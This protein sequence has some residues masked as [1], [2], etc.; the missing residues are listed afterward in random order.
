[1]SAA[2][3]LAR[4]GLGNVWPNPAVGCVIVADGADGGEV[5][6]RGWTQPG[7][8]PHAET[9]ALARAGELA[10]GA[11]AYVTLEPCSHHGKT[12]PCA[13]AL[14]EAGVRRVVAAIADPDPRVGGRGFEKLRKAGIEVETG[15]LAE[16]AEEVNLGYLMR[17]R[18]GRPMITLK[19]ATTLDG[20]IATHRGD[21]QWIT[22]EAARR[23]AHLLR[24]THDAVLVGIGTALA[25]D[26]RLTC[27]LPGLEIRSPVR[28]VADPRLQLPLMSQLARNADEAPTWLLTSAETPRERRTPDSRPPT[29]PERRA[30]FEELG[31]TVLPVRVGADHYPEIDA[32]LKCLG[33]AGLTRVLLE[34]GGG[35]AAA[36]IRA[37]VVDQILWFRAAGIMGGD[38]IA[39]VAPFGVDTLDDLRRFERVSV[40]SVGEDWLE[41]YRVVN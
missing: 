12:P 22:G 18:V 16:A 13:D 29:P 5:V 7:G 23:R 21:S 30:A 3:A 11:T 36:F 19:T 15:L 1:M 31:V 38:G 26:P 4:R 20:R 39:A 34:G 17:R 10:A 40:D 27:R 6:G 25:D 35:L 2:L 33:D 28:I 9:E 24:A 41:T 8:R 37:G 14:S 32:A